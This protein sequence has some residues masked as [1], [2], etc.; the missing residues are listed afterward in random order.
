[1]C[2]RCV[3]DILSYMHQ[4]KQ[5]YRHFYVNLSWVVLMLLISACTE[6]P[7]TQSGFL[8][9]YDQLAE[10]SDE[11]KARLFISSAFDRD[12]YECFNV[13]PVKLLLN[14][15][16]PRDKNAEHQLANLLQQSLRDEFKKHLKYSPDQSSKCLHIKAAITGITTINP[17]TNVIATI[18][19]NPIENGGLSIEAE[20][21][22]A[23]QSQ[24]LA[25]IS[26][27]DEG[28]V[29]S[30]EQTFATYQTYGHAEFLAEK[31]PSIFANLL[32]YPS[33]K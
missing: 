22:D 30:I 20:I 33:E 25:A 1:M 19:A 27:A 18:V 21:L 11:H 15:N 4:K 10:V 24:R 16:S 14:E 29:F 9:N 6:Q 17:V 8:K 13:M 26:W 32:G 28:S 3:F 31:F 2:V 23:H 12:S 7:V 5:K